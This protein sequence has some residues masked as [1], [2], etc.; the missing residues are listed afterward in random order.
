MGK[1]SWF[2]D[3]RINFFVENTFHTKLLYHFIDYI[4]YTTPKIFNK[5][6]KNIMKKIALLLSL[7]TITIST[8]FGQN[9][10][11]K[12]VKYARTEIDVPVG[13]TAKDEYSIENDL[14]S[15]QWLYL[16]K[17]MAEQGVDKQIIQQFEEQ[18]KYPKSTTIEFVSNGGQFSGKKYQLKGDS[19]MKYR[20]LA[21]GTV[22][23]QPLVLNLGFKNDPESDEKFD[24]LI[25]KFIQ[26]KK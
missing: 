13:Y 7:L 12:K 14:F 21:F 8:T 24:D 6:T 10:E 2:I 1:I 4:L 19:K 23:G 15:A 20:I 9:S 17:E 5:S 11:I 25:K 3:I 18:L 16:T 22:D 26:V